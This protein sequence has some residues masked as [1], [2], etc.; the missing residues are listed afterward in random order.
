MS[1]DCFVCGYYN[2]EGGQ[3]KPFG[4]SKKIGLCARCWSHIWGWVR[5]SKAA[6][7]NGQDI[8]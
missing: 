3:L 6:A 8:P 2:Q 5:V 4:G 7:E 1:D